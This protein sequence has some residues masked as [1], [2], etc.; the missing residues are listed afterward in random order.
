MLTTIRAVIRQGKLEPL[1][2]IVLLEGEV[3]VT[4]LA[5]QRPEVFW[6]AASEEALKEVWDNAEDDIYADLLEK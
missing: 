4:F 3:L 1:E 2:D 6:Q 5:E